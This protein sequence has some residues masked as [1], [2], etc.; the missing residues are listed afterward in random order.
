MSS[1]MPK[2]NVNSIV[3][4]SKEHGGKKKK[5]KKIHVNVSITYSSRIM[6]TYNRNNNLLPGAR[7]LCWQPKQFLGTLCGSLDTATSS[8]GVIGNR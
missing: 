3:G 7:R 8:N 5:K 1:S 4:H 6:I 2:H